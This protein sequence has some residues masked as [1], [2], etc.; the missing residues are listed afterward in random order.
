MKSVLRVAF[1]VLVNVVILAA[2]LE[3]AG[4]L[5][6]LWQ[7]GQ[8]FYTSR[9][10]QPQTPAATANP[11]MTG[12]LHAAIH[13]YFG[14][15]YKP[16]V[17]M[18]TRLPHVTFNNHGFLQSADYVRRNPACCTV[19][20]VRSDPNEVIVGVFGGS[21]AASLAVRM[22]EDPAFTKAL[23]AIPRFANRPIRILSFALGGHKQPQQLMILTYYLSLGQPFDLIINA[24][25]INELYSGVGLLLSGIDIGFP[26]FSLWQA[27]TSFI[28]RQAR[29]AHNPES[30]L[31]NYH[32]LMRQRWALR[33]AQC[34]TA[35]CYSL[36]RLVQYW[37]ESNARTDPARDPASLFFFQIN[38]TTAATRGAF[39]PADK[40]WEGAPRVVELVA[41]HWATTSLVMQGLARSR[42]ILYVHALQ[43]NPWF[44]RSTPYV[45]KGSAEGNA[46]QK[47]MVPMGYGAFVAKGRT[48]REQGVNFIDASAVLDEEPSSVYSDDVGHY[49]PRG[50][51]LLAAAIARAVAA[52]DL[53]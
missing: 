47:R 11:F 25:G 5:S 32:V 44:R 8:F 50:Y 52:P 27:L 15:V 41:E 40:N 14:F 19:P 7:N 13:P 3:I 33:V 36:A 23:N 18:A 42:N 48:L 29:E 17:D 39:Q 26:D 1:V 2:L 24:D 35:I 46:Y 12:D 21:V 38:Q 10:P 16:N 49:M 20:S 51:D 4:N 6:F 31:A 34:R 53:R 30:L 9:R 45:S 22:Q 37:H 28:D 43:P